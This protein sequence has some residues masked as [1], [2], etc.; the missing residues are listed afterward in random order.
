[1][2]L[3]EIISGCIAIAIFTF[4]LT[5]VF[6]P[7]IL[8]TPFFPSFRKK[9]WASKEAEKIEQEVLSKT[10]LLYA[11]TRKAELEKQLKALDQQIE[12]SSKP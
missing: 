8:S 9:N 2:I 7:F 5:Q 4:L 3:L 6:L 12:N 11:R 1:M 10:E